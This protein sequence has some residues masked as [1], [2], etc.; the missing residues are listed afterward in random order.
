M[1]KTSKFSNNIFLSHHQWISFPPHELTLVILNKH[2]H[3]DIGPVLTRATYVITN[4]Y[5]D[6]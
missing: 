6:D 5:L 2:N 4:I 1:G 3:I